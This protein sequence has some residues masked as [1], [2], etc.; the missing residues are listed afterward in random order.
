MS[1]KEMVMCASRA[2]TEQSF[3]KSQE[4]NLLFYCQPKEGKGSRFL[5]ASQLYF[6]LNGIRGIDFIASLKLHISQK[7]KESS[8]S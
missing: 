8:L 4:Q 7:N 2:K 3:P 6:L 5:D 1:E